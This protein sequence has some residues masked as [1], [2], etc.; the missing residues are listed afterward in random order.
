MILH[1]TISAFDADDGTL[2]P[3]TLGLLHSL[4]QKNT[5]CFNLA[6]QALQQTFTECL[7]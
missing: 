4:I 3:N 6:E 7:L 2:S 1:A 5:V